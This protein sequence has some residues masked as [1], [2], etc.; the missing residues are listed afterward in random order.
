MHAMPILLCALCELS[1]VNLATTIG[2][3]YDYFSSPCIIT[4][5]SQIKAMRG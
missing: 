4:S 5:V 3:R 1:H 2:D